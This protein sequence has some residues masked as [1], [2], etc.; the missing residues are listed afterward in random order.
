MEWISFG[1]RKLYLARVMT[2][3]AVYIFMKYILTLVMPFFLAFGFLL[4]LQI[5]LRKLEEKLHIKKRILAV[6]LLVLAVGILIWLLWYGA[7]K[8]GRQ[9]L[10]LVRN[11][12]SG[13]ENLGGLVHSCCQE[14]ERYTGIDA[15]AAE[16]AV[17]IHLVRFSTDMKQKAIPKLMNQSVLYVQFFAS[18][19]AFWGITLI[20]AVLLAKDFN[21]IQTDL[22]KYKWYQAAEEIGQKVGK[23][24]A[25]YGK[26]QLA[27][28]GIIGSLCAL[29]LCFL[30][31]KGGMFFGILAGIL[32]AL[33]FIG[34]GIVLIPAALWQLVQGKIKRCMA[35]L[36]LY[37]TCIFLREILEPKFV[38]KRVDI[39]PVVVLFAV[40]TGIRIYGILGV[41]TGPLSLLLIREI[42]RKLPD[43]LT[44]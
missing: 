40:Y 41:V 31:I 25:D 9:I 1:K 4:F 24:A 3:A 27:V 19:A 7:G 16:D 32:D 18:A 6:V 14:L 30:G 37:G 28:L 15:E 39:Y 13:M 44:I 10:F 11:M 29:W 2:A 38:G 17:L 21:R 5:L 33:P 8:I 34:T 26:A 23:L 22:R 36:L 35:V 12:E 20:A 42:W 43:I